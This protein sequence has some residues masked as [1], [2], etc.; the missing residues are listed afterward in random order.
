MQLE[1]APAPSLLRQ[2]LGAAACV[3]LASSAPAI[4]HAAGPAVTQFE[5][6]ALMYGEQGR[7]RVV[8]PFARITRLLPDGQSFSAQFGLDA[9]TGASPTGGSPN[10]RVVTTTTPS[11]NTVTTPADQIPT[12]TFQDLRGSLA[13]EWV[14]PI[15][16]RWTPTLGAHVSREKDYQSVGA[17]G[18]VALE[19]FHRRTTATLGGGADR[20]AVFPEGGIAVGLGDSA[21]VTGESSRSKHVTTL[22]AG[23]SQVVTRRWMVSLNASRTSEQG[24]LTDPY[25]IV[26]VWDAGGYAVDSRREKRPESRTRTSVLASSVYHLAADV[27]YASYRHYHDDWGVSSHTADIKYRHELGHEAFL[28][29][30]VRLYAQAQADFFTFGLPPDTPLP[31]FASADQR[32]GPLRTATLGTTYGFHFGGLPGAFEVR[33]EYMAQWGRGHPEN[34]VGV[35]QG[36]DLFPLQNAGSLLLGYSIAW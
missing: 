13:L 17:S 4:A 5:A 21:E 20:D 36:Y 24:Y 23:I 12:S 14:R 25:K 16:T 34:A 8:E 35:Q 28:Q 32:L 15:G 19:M 6:A 10:G 1:A 26:T 2:R 9:I 33:A 22:L 27:L 29:P 3:L 11:G 31:E 18:K 30:H 7:T